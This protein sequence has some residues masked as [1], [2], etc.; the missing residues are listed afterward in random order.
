L[1]IERA[2]LAQYPFG[3]ADLPDV[4]EEAGPADH[5]DLAGRQP[6]R[7][8]D[9]AAPRADPL[10]VAP[11]VRVLRLQR[12]GQAEQRLIDRALHLLVEPPHILGVSQRLLVRGVEAAIGDGEIVARRRAYSCCHTAACGTTLSTSESRRT[13]ENGLVR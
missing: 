9:A 13:G 10:G 5:V 11:R 3:N 6:E 2:G 7:R 12:V 8:R 4:V 1:G